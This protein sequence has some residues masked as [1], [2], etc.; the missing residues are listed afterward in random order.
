M[1]TKPLR[2]KLRLVLAR[3]CVCGYYESHQRTTPT[4]VSGKPEFQ[5]IRLSK[6]IIRRRPISKK[7][8]TALA[9]LRIKSTRPALPPQGRGYKG[10]VM[11]M[12]HG[13]I[14]VRRSWLRNAP[15][16]K[17]HS[18]VQDIAMDRPT[19]GFMRHQK[20]LVTSPHCSGFSVSLHGRGRRST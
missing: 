13:V 5:M 4:W 7:R 18:D 20:R 15:Q 3:I 12:V 6:D 9:T 16:E 14:S 10:M 2:K 11:R 8:P 19:I 17:F 1:S